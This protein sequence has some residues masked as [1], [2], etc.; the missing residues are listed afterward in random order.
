MEAILQVKPA[1][2][3]RAAPRTR[4]VTWEDPAI[5]AKAA[6]TMSGLAFLR[7][8]R[9]GS[10]PP[11][12]IIPLVDF[13]LIEVEAGRVVF[14]FH[15][16]EW[17]YNP[18]GTVHGGIACTVLD[19]AAACAVHSTL[20]AGTGVITLEV[21]INYLRP[22]TSEAGPMRCEATLIHKGSRIAVA[23]AKMLD[24]KARLCTTAVSTCLIFEQPAKKRERAR[25]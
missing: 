11:P 22:I 12:P 23:E 8:M 6:A 18:A 17:Q 20:P 14:E 3:D 25:R 21:K 10:I 1:L 7:G 15:P 4:S 13:H 9:D 24:R 19:S 2:K 16:A 5:N